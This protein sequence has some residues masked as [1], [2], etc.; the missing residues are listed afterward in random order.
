MSVDF[1]E[2]KKTQRGR[3]LAKLLDLRWHPH[4][5]LADVG[6]NRYSAR[7][8]ELKRLGYVIED[9]SLDGNLGGGFEY[10]LM[11]KNAGTPQVKRVKVFLT[12]AEAQSI[13]D[14]L[15]TRCAGARSAVKDALGSFR[16]NRHKL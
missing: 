12:E 16:A 4:Y 14:H 1:A 5:E 8:H 9:R 11:S 3:V 15:P 7:I 10:R 6:G 13:V 2:L